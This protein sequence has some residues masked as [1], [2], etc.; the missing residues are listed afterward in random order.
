[1]EEPLELRLRP[2][3]LDR[4]QARAAEH[5]A[6]VRVGH[7]QGVAVEAVERLELAL[8][9]GAPDLVR[10]GGSQRHRPRMPRRAPPSAWLDQTMALE[11]GPDRRGHRQHEGGVTRGEVVEELAWPPPWVRLPAGDEESLHLRRGLVGARLRGAVLISKAVEAALLE[12]AEPLVA[13]LAADVEASAELGHGVEALLMGE[14]EAG[15]FGHGAGLYPGHSA[16][17]LVMDYAG[18]RI[19]YPCCRS[20]VLPMYPVRTPKRANPPLQADPR[21][22]RSRS[23][24]DVSASVA[25]GYRCALSLGRLSVPLFCGTRQ[26]GRLVPRHRT[27]R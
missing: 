20:E 26:S 7:R 15:A 24:R 19:C 4:R 21:R 3:L 25:S 13:G 14:D 27:L 12:A 23:P 16:S 1:M 18:E 2:V 22:Q 5:V 17:G 9:V 6:R 11:D 10:S 8:E